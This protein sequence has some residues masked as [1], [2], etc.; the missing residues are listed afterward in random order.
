MF[1]GDASQFVKGSQEQPE[2]HATALVLGRLYMY[3]L[4]Q[5]VLEVAVAGM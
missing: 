1:C 5:D 4:V 2:E 3:A